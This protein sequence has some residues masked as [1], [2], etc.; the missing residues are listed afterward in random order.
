[1]VKYNL[2]SEFYKEFTG[3]TNHP[4]AARF[5]EYNLFIYIF[6]MYCRNVNIKDFSKFLNKTI[7]YYDTNLKDS[8]LGQIYLQS[9]TDRVVANKKDY[10]KTAI[11]T[12][13]GRHSSF[14]DDITNTLKVYQESNGIILIT[15]SIEELMLVFDLEK[16]HA[17]YMQARLQKALKKKNNSEG[18]RR[19]SIPLSAIPKIEET[20]LPSS[21]TISNAAPVQVAEKPKGKNRDIVSSV[22]RTKLRAPEIKFDE[23]AFYSKIAKGLEGCKVNEITIEMILTMYNKEK[24]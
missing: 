14:H 4:L 24:K 8:S 3:E 11:Q 23:K 10:S 1:M 13:I 18:K 17:N 21:D 2:F 22:K 15:E 12:E 19:I 5:N 16:T 20:S 9:W 7:V 6:I